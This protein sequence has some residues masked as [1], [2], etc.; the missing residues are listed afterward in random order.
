QDLPPLLLPFRTKGDDVAF[1][2]H[3]DDL[4]AVGPHMFDLGEDSHMNG[5]QL[6]SF[7]VNTSCGS[8]PSS[9]KSNDTLQQFL[10]FSHD[11]IFGQDTS[12]LFN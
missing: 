4:A 7:P 2:V 3:F 8:H 6:L 1:D 11:D 12:S 10:G 9:T 5:D